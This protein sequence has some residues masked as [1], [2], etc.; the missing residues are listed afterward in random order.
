[1]DNW[2][3]QPFELEVIFPAIYLWFFQGPPCKLPNLEDNPSL[4]VTAA[5][6]IETLRSVSQVDACSKET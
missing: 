6:C 1:M 4:I 2:G 3:L 5:N